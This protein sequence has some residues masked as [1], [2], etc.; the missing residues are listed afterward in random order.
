MAPTDLVQFVDSNDLTTL[1]KAWTEATGQPGDLDDYCRVIEA[2][3]DQDLPGRALSFATE[4][5]DALVGADRGGDARAL[6]TVLMQ[7]GAH[8]DKLTQRLFEFIQTQDSAKPWFEHICSMAGISGTAATAKSLVDYENFCR[9]TEGHVLFH[10]AGWGEGLVTEFRTGTLEVVIDFVNGRAREMPLKAAVESLT[11]L[12]SDDLRSMRILRKDALEDLVSDEPSI[13]IRKAAQ[14]FRGKITST[15]VKETLC[16]SV[17][18]TK[19]WNGFWKK[20]KAAAAHDPW[21]PS[22]VR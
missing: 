19:K 15:K 17:V 3:C 8:N 2:L 6:A 21:S 5:I 11:P 22:L 16:P 1:E 7:R 13:L 14:M 9:F 12:P 18:P 10:R 20:A 4:M